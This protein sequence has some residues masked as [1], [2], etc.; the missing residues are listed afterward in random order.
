MKLTNIPFLLK[1]VI[2][3]K[4]TVSKVQKYIG[5]KAPKGT[6]WLCGFN[7]WPWLPPDWLGRYPL[8]FSWA[9]GHLH[10]NLEVTP[11]YLSSIQA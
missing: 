1:T 8:I 4:Q 7:L 6:Q 11:A 5:W 10:T 9:P 3:M 2:G